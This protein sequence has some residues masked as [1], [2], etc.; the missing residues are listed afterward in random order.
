MK[1]TVRLNSRRIGTCAL[2]RGGAE[3]AAEE[4]RF[5]HL[6]EEAAFDGVQ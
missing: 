2:Q 1:G 6:A 4:G 3:R 5:E